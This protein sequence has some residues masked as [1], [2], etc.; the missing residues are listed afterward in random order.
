MT[1]FQIWMVVISGAQQAT[2]ISLLTYL[3]WFLQ[4]R[5]VGPFG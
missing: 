2:L 3:G 1:R 5:Q 4:F